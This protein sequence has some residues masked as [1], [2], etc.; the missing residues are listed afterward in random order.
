MV[1]EDAKDGVLNLLEGTL[2]PNGS[3][4]MRGDTQRLDAVQLHLFKQIETLH[5]QKISG[6]F[7]GGAAV[8]VSDPA[9]MGKT[10][11]ESGAASY[12]MQLSI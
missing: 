12:M 8:E 7:S 1:H 4:D 3:L 11:S 2:E 6:S 5:D 10:I 9:V